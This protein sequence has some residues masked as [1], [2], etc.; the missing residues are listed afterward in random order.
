MGLAIYQVDAFTDRP[1]G[2]NPAM[3]CLLPGP[4]SNGWMQ[5][6][7]AE[8]N[9]ALLPRTS[10][11]RPAWWPRPIRSFSRPSRVRRA[12]GAKH[13]PTA[14]EEPPAAEERCADAGHDRQQYVYPVHGWHRVSRS[15]AV[16][17]IKR[18]RGVPSDGS[19]PHGKARGS[20]RGGAPAR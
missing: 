10:S 15:V 12:H 16:A 9:Q 20:E 17:K 2:G 6:A 8:L 1:F 4:A 3:V 18:A 13:T 14:L 11:T 5:W 19:R 7:A